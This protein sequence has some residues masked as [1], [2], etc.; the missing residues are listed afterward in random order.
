MNTET[1]ARLVLQLETRQGQHLKLD[2]TGGR[3]SIGR[4]FSNDL[5]VNDP[6]MGP[7]QA[8][9][10]ARD[11][12][13]YLEV[14]DDTNPVLVNQQ[15]TEGAPIRL[16][17]G[18]RITMGRTRM[19]IYA[20]D[21]A[22]EPARRLLLTRWLH[23]EHMSIVTPLLLLAGICLLD[24][25]LEYQLYSISLDWKDNALGALIGGVIVLIWAG[26]WAGVGQLLRHQHHFKSQLTASTLV[27]LV[28]IVLG[29]AAR[30]LQYPVNNVVFD[31]VV[32]WGLFLGSF[33]LLL[34]FNL[35][36][37]TNLK[38]TT[39]AAV[40]VTATLFGLGY[41][42]VDYMQQDQVQT[43]PA[44]PGV[45]NPPFAHLA[46]EQDMERYL[47]RVASLFAEAEAAAAEPAAE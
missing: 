13:V 9:F 35:Y 42:G 11:G 46:P 23:R 31:Y 1:T 18:D 32:Q 36:F 25:T 34:K 10:A 26:I 45:V 44:Y 3:H 41:L 43:Q 33:A 39:A 8:V 28:P 6:Y 16:Q 7:R 2:P 19:R 15:A 12:G 27:L 20:E 29:L 17:P 47:A 4:D 24:A 14:L 30:Y 37:A 40:A 21:H 38:H 22:F 5:V